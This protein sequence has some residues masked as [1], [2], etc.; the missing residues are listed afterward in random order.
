MNYDMTNFTTDVL[1]QS[2]TLPVLVDFW[3]AWCGPCR[4]L[5]PVLERLA[6]KYTGQWRLVKIDT[7]RFPD[8]A[9]QYGVR[10]IPSV[11]LFVDGKVVDEFTGAQPDFAIEQ[12]LK[13][14]LPDKHAKDVQEAERLMA[15]NRREEAQT[16]LEGVL[17]AEPSGEQ[18][19]VLLAELLVFRNPER[20]AE[21]VQDILADSKV[22]D[23]AEAIRVFTRLGSLAAT[24]DMLPD[25]PARQQYVDAI[26]ALEERNFDSALDKFIEVIREDRYYDDDGSRKA[27]IAIFKY[28]GEDHEITRRHRRSFDRALY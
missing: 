4:I 20:A 27:C 12:W 5:G 23:K 8:I 24:P 22:Y 9:N 18:A 16:L 11:K 14:A 25:G 19:R 13:R 6:E 7:E 3:A 26:R 21:L 28:L 2:K 15:E 10:G 1:E 17:A